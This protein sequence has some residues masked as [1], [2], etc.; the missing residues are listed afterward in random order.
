MLLFEDESGWGRPVSGE[1][2]GTVLHDFTQMRLVVLNA[3]EGARTGRS[4]PFAGVAESLVQR[5][6]PAVIAMQFEISDEAAIMFAEG[7]Y[8]S[9]ANGSPVDAAVAAARLAMFAKRSDDIEWGTPALYMRVPD[10]RIFDLPD[11]QR[12]SRSTLRRAR[13]PGAA[14]SCAGPRQRDD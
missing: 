4:D 10:G 2:L 13:R 11:R 3:C 12:P 14:P 5:E 7:F 6:I 9:I 1:K 8:S